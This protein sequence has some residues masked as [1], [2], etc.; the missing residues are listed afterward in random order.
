MY[1]RVVT[2]RDAGRLPL[3]LTGGSVLALLS[4]L[5]DD[6]FFHLLPPPITLDYALVGVAM[7]LAAIGPWLA[8]PTSSRLSALRLEPGALV[9]G[10]RRISADDVEAVSIAEA[11]RGT[12]VG[13]RLRRGVVFLE[14]ERVADAQRVIDALGKTPEALG[15]L[16]KAHGGW[17]E[18]AIAQGTISVT[19]LIF[20]LLYQAATTMPDAPFGSKALGIPG[21]VFAVLSL[22]VLVVRVM[23]GSRLSL[24]K[25]CALE[26]HARLHAGNGV[27][28]EAPG[29]R[30]F[31]ADPLVRRDEPTA[32]WLARLD[33][34]ASQKSAYRGDVPARDA[35]VATLTDEAAQVD[36]RMAAARLLKRRHGS[37]D[38]ELV[39]VVVDP[40]VRVRVEAALDDD[41]DAAERI[42]Q[43]GPVFQ[44][45]R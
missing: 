19:T 24:A 9:I 35:L 11:H 25:D 23:S 27:E 44:V 39:R 3:V 41:D 18:V 4:F 1:V 40:L 45:R 43:L 15:S 38:E 37:T 42:D 30:A 13:L 14:V 34:A 20:A 16:P 29:A 33:A 32:A 6:L 28:G 10:K 22:L 8:R 12:S 31:E 5:V 17:G 36:A 2:K 21:V 26:A 7:L